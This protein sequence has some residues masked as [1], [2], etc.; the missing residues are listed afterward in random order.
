M[1]AFDNGVL[2]QWLICYIQLRNLINAHIAISLL[3]PSILYF[4]PVLI[5]T[6]GIAEEK[7]NKLSR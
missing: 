2:I 7:N 1:N 5:R 6:W 3:H 4:L